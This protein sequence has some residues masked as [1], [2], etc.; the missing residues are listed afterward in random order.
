MTGTEQAASLYW[1]SAQRARCGTLMER[2]EARSNL[3]TLA[4]RE[5]RIGKMAKPLVKGTLP[6]VGDECNG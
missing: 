1:R 2:I 6:M 5:D 3:R 4:A